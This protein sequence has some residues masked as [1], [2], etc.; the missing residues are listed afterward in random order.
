MQSLQSLHTFALPAHCQKLVR[1]TAPEQLHA[2]DFEKPF[3]ILGEGSNCV[4]LD[5]F[6]G[7][8]LQMA[9]R[10][11]DVNERE[12]HYLV[13]VAAG[14]NW[15]QL[16][17]KLLKMGITGLEN[18]VLIPGTIGAAPVQNI[19]AYGVELADVFSH[20]TG[21]HIDKQ[22]FETLDKS[23]CQFGYRDSV[24]KQALHGRF[25]I[26]EVVLK[27]P[28]QWQPVLGYGPLRDLTECE[29][30]A[31]HVAERVMQI[32]R[33]KLPDPILCA[34][35]GS[36][37]KN[38]MVSLE[39]AKTLRVRYQSMPTYPVDENTVKLAAGW[40]IEQA[41]LKGHRIG[42]IRVYDKQALV[43]VND[44]QGDGEELLAMITHIQKTVFAKFTV[45][46][47]PEVRL[48]GRG[49]EFS[50]GVEHG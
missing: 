47:I 22:S 44:E 49:G 13:R 36:F 5:D 38:P 37:F 42:G 33:S 41:G 50:K 30:D 48:I 14:E 25:V 12:D 4:F 10:G 27:L 34:N 6:D 19:G 46:L 11:I 35:A 26:T 45:E 21:Y 7:T 43:L 1:I 3:F 9:N 40:L 23:A 18:L 39:L 31:M 24:F 16:V 29:V 15:H 20:L 2:I 28:K 17:I 8:V 32:R